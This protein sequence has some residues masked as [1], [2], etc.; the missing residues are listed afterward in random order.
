MNSYRFYQLNFEATRRCNLACPSCMVGCNDVE[1]VRDKA[2]DELSFDEIIER[3]FLPAR[4]LNI[5]QI[6]FSGGEFLLRED[7]VELVEAAAN[8]GF[9]VGILTNGSLIDSNRLENLK[10]A[11]G[12]RLVMTFGINSI[13]DPVLQRMSRDAELE[14][15]LRAME[16]CKEHG[17]GRHVVVTVGSFNAGDLD[18]TLEWLTKNRLTFNRAP[19][20]RRNSGAERF[21]EL[22]YSRDDI[23]HR[24]HPALRRR[25]NGYTSQTPF[26]LSPELHRRASGGG[27][28]NGTVPQNPPVG[29]W[30]G[31]WIS[32]SA[33]GDV[34]PC[35]ILQD[36]LV[37]GNVRK[38]SLPEIVKGSP[39]FVDLL[40]RHRLKGRCGRCR[41]KATCGGCRALAYFDSG[42]YLAEDP[43]CFFEPHDERTASP[44]E[45]ETN[46]VFRHYLRLAAHAG[47][48][49]RPMRGNA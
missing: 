48:Y 18:T 34:A 1:L 19:F 2:K 17:I 47:M 23:E 16:L 40:D 28:M 11:A 3:V 14:V 46:R 7:A 45:Q 24:I 26:F 22:G 36:E 31:N 8:Q 6:G 9:R 38:Q 21:A 42:D 15:T 20:T 49:Q 41:Y 25:L 30:C 5:I 29:C 13:V 33:E 43:T 10:K 35:V 12:G 39:I 44:H 4:E 37:A 32:V 27:Q